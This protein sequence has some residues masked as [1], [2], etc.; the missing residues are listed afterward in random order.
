MSQVIVTFL[1]QTGE[2]SNG[3][4]AVAPRFQGAVSEEITS[5]GTSQPTTAASTASQGRGF[6]RI[7]NAGS[8]KIWVHAAAA[9]TAIVLTTHMLAG[10][11][12]A[13]FS[14]NN[15]DKIAVINDT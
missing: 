2:A 9:P 12:E 7:V 3:A 11:T 5:S 4:E 13:I 15:G 10:N 6:V 8:D 14:V 1:T